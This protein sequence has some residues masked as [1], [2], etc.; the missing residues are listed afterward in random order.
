MHNSGIIY[1][2]IIQAGLLARRDCCSDKEV[3][4]EVVVDYHE[5]ARTESMQRDRLV[6]RIKNVG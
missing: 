6:L 2:F 1:A 5:W 3:A 4:Q